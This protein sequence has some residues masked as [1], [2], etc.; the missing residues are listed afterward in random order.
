MMYHRDS[1]LSQKWGRLMPATPRVSGRASVAMSLCAILISGPSARPALGQ[2]HYTYEF[3][4][5]PP[6]SELANPYAINNLGH[7]AGYVEVSGTDRGFVWTPEGGTQLLPMPPGVI[8]MQAT[9]INDLDHICGW[10]DD[11]AAQEVK[12]FLWDGREF[13]FI[14]SPYPNTRIEALDVN[15]RD[16][17]VG[18]IIGAPDGRPLRA[19]LWENGV[20]TELDSLIGVA[21]P[22][23]VAI[24]DDS[25][26]TGYAGLGGDIHAWILDRDG[27]HWLPENGLSITA[28]TGIS[29]S[30]E[31][32]GWGYYQPTDEFRGC[33][34]EGAALYLITPPAEFDPIVCRSVNN[35][36]RVVGSSDPDPGPWRG[37][38][39][40]SGT[41]Y[42]FG[43]LV[44]GI[45][46][47]IPVDINE[48]GQVA[49]YAGVGP[50]V[51][52]PVWK[53]GD[54]TGDCAVGM[55]DLLL[56]LRN[57]GATGN[58]PPRGDVD[59]N[60]TV[61]LSDLTLLL[62]NWGT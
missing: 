3:I 39:W 34:W 21:Q 15:R 58:L 29:N 25:V 30:G 59:L 2:C 47:G 36:G 32:V 10:V 20:L 17:V 52:T 5:S 61:D 37:F 31:V 54:L 4:F 9:G 38:I 7:V 55:D 53:R 51:L 50:V 35:A 49:A 33:I 22:R 56:V 6:N 19:F 48:F 28:T 62:S 43:A 60:G 8:R 45:S 42:P 26:M 24:N 13:T 40:Q 12:A 14:P 18:S 41:V 11:W 1:F 44:S 46:V 27:V 23:M 57:F 16:Q